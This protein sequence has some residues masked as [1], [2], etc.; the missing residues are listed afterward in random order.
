MTLYEIIMSILGWLRLAFIIAFPF[1]ALALLVDVF[2]LKKH[3]GWRRRALT[4]LIVTLLAF[5]NYAPT[6]F[7]SSRINKESVADN[8][9]ELSKLSEGSYRFATEKI[10]GTIL[11]SE[12]Y[13]DV[14]WDE[15]DFRKKEKELTRNLYYY[16]TPVYCYRD[17]RLTVFKIR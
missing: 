9:E 13:S 17:S 8:L 7:V 15:L 4:I 11:I 14:A 5:S 2:I 12:N 10:S 6:I 1:V 16:A 3:T